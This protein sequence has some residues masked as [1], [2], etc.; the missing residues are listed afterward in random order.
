MAATTAQRGT[1]TASTTPAGTATQWGFFQKCAANLGLKT[2][3]TS[4]ASTPIEDDNELVSLP[5]N[6]TPTEPAP[7]LFSV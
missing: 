4:R 3:T 2:P 1:T 6:A 7:S 5:F